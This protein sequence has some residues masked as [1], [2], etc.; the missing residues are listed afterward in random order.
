M[1]FPSSVLLIEVI[2]N[3]VMT[4]GTPVRPDPKRQQAYDT[5]FLAYKG[6]QKLVFQEALP[7]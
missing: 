2:F 3:R 5:Y 6:L 7:A 4:H 1:I